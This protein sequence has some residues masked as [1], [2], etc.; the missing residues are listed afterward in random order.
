MA[1]KT[2]YGPPPAHVQPTELNGQLIVIEGADGSGRSTQISLLKESLEADGKFVVEIGLK[3]S[4]LVGDQLEIA[5]QGNTLTRLT[6]SLFYAT[7]FFDQFENQVVPALRAGFVV[8][9]D[10]Y[11]YTLMLRDLLRGIDEDY[12]MTLYGPALM[13]SA[14]FY[15]DVKPKTLAYRNFKN[16]KTLDYWESGLDLGLSRDLYDNFIA[17]HHM[18]RKRFLEYAE[19]FNFEVLDGQK[20]VE[21]V[22]EDLW[23]RTRKILKNA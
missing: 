18:L 17:Y 21:Q 19:R 4:A 5:K 9:S 1:F 22:Q 13:P 14:V 23:A 6:M 7:D 3:R 16:N 11:V 10:R 20:T 12:L 8:L 15:L 2:I